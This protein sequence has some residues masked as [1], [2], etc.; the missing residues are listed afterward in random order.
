MP[1][2][3]LSI[4]NQARRTLPGPDHL[5]DLINWSCDSATAIDF[6]T[7]SGDVHQISYKLLDELTSALAQHIVEALQAAGA[8]AED[9]IVPVLI[10][11]SP[12]LYIAWIAILKAG[13]AFCPITID[14]PAERVKF[15][16]RDVSASLV[17]I[18]VRYERWLA[19]IAPDIATLAVSQSTL[20]SGCRVTPSKVEIEVQKTV[21]RSQSLAYIMYTSGQPDYT[22][23]FPYRRANSERRRVNRTTQRCQDKS[24]GSLSST[25]SSRRAYTQFPAFSAICFPNVRCLCIRDF[26][27]LI[28]RCNT[29]RSG[30][31]THAG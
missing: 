8:C 6:W 14:T 20:H 4:L 16:L 24:Q 29:G 28:Q 10:S 5:H 19:E 15:I 25:A 12:E 31:R 21:L 7:D 23:G 27:S 26:L 9:T 1:G 2:G 22:E 18:A 11:Q 30:S 13:A 17:L 3:E